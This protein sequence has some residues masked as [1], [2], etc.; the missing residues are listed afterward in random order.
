MILPDKYDFEMHSWKSIQ[1]I[2]RNIET[3]IARSIHGKG[4]SFN[5]YFKGLNTVHHG[6][7]IDNHPYVWSQYTWSRH[8]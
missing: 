1:S 2:A 5:I 6:R 7:V 8:F 4:S 3:L